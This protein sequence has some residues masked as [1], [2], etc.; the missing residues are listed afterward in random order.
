MPSNLWRRALALVKDKRSL[1]IAR[2]AIGSRRPELE[3]AVI[4]A[5]SHDDAAVDYRNIQRVFTWIRASPPA[6]K[7]VLW[8]LK[9]RMEKTR[10]WVVAVK[11]LML[12]HGL[13]CLKVPALADVGRLPFDLSRFHDR[14]SA[15]SHHA[16]ALSSFVRSYFAYLDHKSAFLISS[17]RHS[18]S[19]ATSLELDVSE[20]RQL[21]T[22][23]DMLLQIRPCSDNMSFVLV[24]EAMDC[25]VIEI[26]EVYSEIC[27]GVAGVLSRVRAAAASSDAAATLA[28]LHKAAAQSALLPSYFEVCRR[29]GVLNATEFPPVEQIPV[30]DI[31]DIERTLCGFVRS[32][33]FQMG[34]EKKIADDTTTRLGEEEEENWRF[35][36]GTV[37]KREWVAFH[38]DCL[39]RP[40]GEQYGRKEGIGRVS[41]E[42]WKEWNEFVE[43]QKN[44]RSVLEQSGCIAVC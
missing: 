20:L 39:L 1:C 16:W 6:L 40:E 18:T 24:L 37:V 5:T 33:R 32:P 15:P 14:F 42:V 30:E 22:C 23:L 13:F 34:E 4:K 25:V 12:T 10:S 3:A 43:W 36:R 44:Q 26:F 38:D 35:L 41:D 17:R 9:R 11:G 28:V 29:L 19:N 2:M 8:A 27:N 7:A 21:Q 31:R